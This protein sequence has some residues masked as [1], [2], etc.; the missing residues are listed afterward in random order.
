MATE[1]V[2]FV[3]FSW[4]SDEKDAAVAPTLPVAVRREEE[5]I[6]LAPAATAHGCDGGDDGAN[7]NPRVP[8]NNNEQQMKIN[9]SRIF[10]FFYLFRFCCEAR[11]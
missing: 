1:R 3:R 11:G 2:F 6:L 4:F 7:W 5:K 9:D 10:S 8:R